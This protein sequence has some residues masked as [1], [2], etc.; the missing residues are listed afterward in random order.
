MAKRTDKTS[1]M[2]MIKL[3]VAIE[4][5]WNRP[6]SEELTV[7]EICE[8]IRAEFAVDAGDALI[9]RTIRKTIPGWL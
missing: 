5:L 9:I 8:S 7:A 1:P 6:L 3:T 4:Y 2:M